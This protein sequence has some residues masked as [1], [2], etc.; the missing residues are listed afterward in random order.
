MLDDEQ[1]IEQQLTRYR[2]LRGAVAFDLGFADRVMARL[3]AP[4]RL[5]DEL[6]PVF[7][8]LTPLAVAAALLL[9]TM[10]LLN[11]RASQQSLVDRV[12]GMPTVTVATAYALDGDLSAWGK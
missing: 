4:R 10:N 5:S 12:L 1:D 8:R 6:Q 2:A 11:T 3:A 9:A 7:W